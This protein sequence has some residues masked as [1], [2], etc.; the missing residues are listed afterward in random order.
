MSALLP[1]GASSAVAAA[2]AEVARK[3]QQEDGQVVDSKRKA[4]W[5]NKKSQASTWQTL[6]TSLGDSARQEKFLK[7]GTLCALRPGTVSLAETG[8]FVCSVMLQAHGGEGQG[9]EW[10]DSE[11]TRRGAGRRRAGR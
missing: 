1:A 11:R 10:A 8:F 6:A 2:L 5:G 7:Y 9:G 3:K 4:L